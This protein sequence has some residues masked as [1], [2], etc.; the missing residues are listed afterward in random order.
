MVEM[1]WKEYNT[2]RPQNFI[3]NKPSELAAIVVVS[4]ALQHALLT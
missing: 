1:W 3:G 2:I 4:S